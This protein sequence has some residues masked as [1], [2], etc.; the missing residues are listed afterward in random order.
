[1]KKFKNETKISKTRGRSAEQTIYRNQ[2]N[3][4][5]QWKNKQQKLILI[6][7]FVASLILEH[8]SMTYQERLV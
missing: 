5:V 1:M 6:S 2:T 3:S 8:Q 4:N 7:I